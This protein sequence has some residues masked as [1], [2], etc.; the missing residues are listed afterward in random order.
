[1]GIS[2]VKVL[3]HKNKNKKIALIIFF[4]SLITNLLWAPLFFSGHDN[5][6]LIIL[7][8]IL[9]IISILLFW[10]IDKGAA[11]LLVPLLCWCI[12]ASFLNWKINYLN[13]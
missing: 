6:L 11:L 1:M 5:G 10:K 4:I 13:K 7:I 9:T 12:F 3:L 2:L 8:D